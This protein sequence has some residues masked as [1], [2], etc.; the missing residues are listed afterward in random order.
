VAVF[1]VSTSAGELIRVVVESYDFG[2]G[3]GSNVSSGTSD[4]T[5][6]VDAFFTFFSIQVYERGKIHV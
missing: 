2:V 5:A 6:N 3:K 4:S 1:D